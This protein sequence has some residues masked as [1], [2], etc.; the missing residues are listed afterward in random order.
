MRNRRWKRLISS[1]TKHFNSKKANVMEN[2]LLLRADLHA[3]FD[4]FLI[5]IDP[6]SLPDSLLV[7][8]DESLLETVYSGFNEKI[9]EP[10][11][12]VRQTELKD[13]LRLH[14]IE[15]QTKASKF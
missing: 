9:I 13:N 2:G 8:V 3:L 11:C 7:R 6:D 4:Q 14:F 5:S 15:C 12:S 10:H 1:L